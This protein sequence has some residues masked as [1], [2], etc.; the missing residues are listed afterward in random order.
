MSVD[1]PALTLEALLQ[2]LP[3][4]DF[5]EDSALQILHVS[6]EPDVLGLNFP[7][8]RELDVQLGNLPC[9]VSNRLAPQIL[10]EGAALPPVGLPT[11]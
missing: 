10:E 4:M 3:R 7:R 2:R 6:A 9:H 1:A 11:D 5:L 8:T